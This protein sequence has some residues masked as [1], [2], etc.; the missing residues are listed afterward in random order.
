MRRI[1][2]LIQASAK[3]LIG[4]RIS[5]NDTLLDQRFSDSS[6]DC[7][8]DKISLFFAAHLLSEF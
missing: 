2:C 8:R 4:L 7:F 6:A 3:C 5:R 1:R